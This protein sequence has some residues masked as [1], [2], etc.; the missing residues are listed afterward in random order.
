MEVD[1]PIISRTRIIRRSTQLQSIVNQ[2]VV[3][4][5]I[6]GGESNNRNHGCTRV[7]TEVISKRAG[8]N[9]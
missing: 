6:G 1:Y 2:Q 4:H 9:D 8:D 7:I 3:H 5:H